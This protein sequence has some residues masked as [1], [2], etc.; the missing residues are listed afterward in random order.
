VAMPVARGGAPLGDKG[1]E[2]GVHAV[3]V[4]DGRPHKLAALAL[5][6]LWAAW[7]CI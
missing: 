2:A 6:L 1:L 7:S 3:G 4:R 5:L